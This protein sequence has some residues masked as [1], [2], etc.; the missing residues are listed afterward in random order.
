MLNDGDLFEI[1]KRRPLHGQVFRYKGNPPFESAGY[2]VFIVVVYEEC[3][4]TL[5][6]V[7]GTSS[8]EK[9]L[10]ALFKQSIHTDSTTVKINAGKYDFFPRETL[11]D[12]NSVSEIRL[13]ALNP[14]DF[15]YVHN[16]KMKPEDLQL[17]KEAIIK[18]RLVS[19]RV[20]EAIRN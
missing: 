13:S 5:F 10:D 15:K 6:M 12:C 11:F 2:H 14:D 3:T 9:R 16:G 8:I 4:N 19:E 1:F 17:I 20:K 18:S 7:N